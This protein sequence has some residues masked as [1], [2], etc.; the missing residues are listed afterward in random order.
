MLVLDGNGRANQ[1]AMSNEVVTAMMG[2]QMGESSMSSRR[3]L[4]A[5]SA[6]DLKRASRHFLNAYP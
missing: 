2:R 6:N 5:K 1:T 4:A 3:V